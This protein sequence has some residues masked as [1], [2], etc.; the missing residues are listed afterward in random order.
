MLLMT[1]VVP[2]SKGADIT[3]GAHTQQKARKIKAF[4][5]IAASGRGGLAPLAMA[6]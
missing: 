2:A 5:V 6:H 1:S 4:L 3:I